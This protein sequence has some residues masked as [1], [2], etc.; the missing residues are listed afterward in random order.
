M[1]VI[2]IV[3]GKAN[4]A[5]MNGVNKVVYQ[6]AS[7]QAESGQTVSVWGITKDLSENYGERNFNTRLFKAS[8]NPF[9]LPSGIRNAFKEKKGKAVV[10]IHGGWIPVFS[11]LSTL[12]KELGIPFVFTPHGAYN[13]VAMER[14]QFMKKLYFEFFERK[15]LRNASRLHCL[16]ASEV[17][18]L[19][20]IYRTRKSV[21]LPYGYEAEGTAI[22]PSPSKGRKFIIGFVGRL[23]VYTKGLDLLVDAFL[24]FSEE[25][26][27]SE[28]W[29]VGDSPERAVFERKVKSMGLETKVKFWGSRFGEEKENLLRQMDVFAHP[30]RNEGLPASILEAAG[31][32]IPVLVTEAT[33]LAEL[34]KRYKC[35][36]AVPDNNAWE[37]CMGLHKLHANWKQGQF[38]AMGERARSLVA[39]EFNWNSILKQF[40][41]L[42]AS[43]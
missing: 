36:I 20:R 23:D 6:L 14:S 27:N 42:Y 41:Q 22:Q 8:L 7:R 29:I 43:V 12:L 28:L 34:V 38:P 17:N 3:L 21:L 4:P 40:E 26:P 24:E 35:G 33:N 2:H 15:V 31:Y 9:G 5:R 39:Q 18:G 37:I 32:G 10:H 13:V 1:E 16:G 25:Q 19:Q 11:S 30:S